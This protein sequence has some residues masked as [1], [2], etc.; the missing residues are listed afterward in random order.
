LTQE[1]PFYTGIMEAERT[2]LKNTEKSNAGS[3]YLAGIGLA[4]ALVGAVFVYLLGSSF[5]QAS[6]TREWQETPC[7][8]IRSAV[9]ERS[10]K[11][12]TR[13]FSWNVEYNYDFGGRSYSSKFHTPR[14]AKWSSSKKSSEGL[15]R[16]Y[17]ENK[18]AICYVNPAAPSQAILKHDS[19]GG[20]Y[21]IWFPMLFVIG[22][23]GI[24]VSALKGLKFKSIRC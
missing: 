4:V 11:N 6:E 3:Y 9:K 23:L 1:A 18:K 21:S 19:K 8:V 5:F 20:G 7:L 22:G 2:K 15:I 16:Q 24:T 12:I 13:E 10:A 14:A 17:P